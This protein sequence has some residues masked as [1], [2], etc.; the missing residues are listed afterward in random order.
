MMC[1]GGLDGYMYM[2]TDY[3][4]KEKEQDFFLQCGGCMHICRYYI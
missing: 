1:D 3:N 2:D 4:T